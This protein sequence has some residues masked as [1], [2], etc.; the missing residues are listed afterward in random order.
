[1]LLDKMIKATHN[2]SNKTK[3]KKLKLRLI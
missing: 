2:E 1:M 3:V